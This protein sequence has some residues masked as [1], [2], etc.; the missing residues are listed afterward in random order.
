MVERLASPGHRSLFFIWRLLVAG[1]LVAPLLGFSLDH[2]F[3]ERV[4]DHAHLLLE[5]D[6][7]QDSVPE[8][9]HLFQVPHDHW[10][11]ASSLAPGPS[12]RW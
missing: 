6:L 9:L 2:H 1:L 11:G 10:H 8:H 5:E 12:L 7:S 3:G 4:P